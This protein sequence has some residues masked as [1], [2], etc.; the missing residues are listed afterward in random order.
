M[1]LRRYLL[2]WMASLVG[3]APIAP[4]HAQSLDAAAAIYE[5][6]IYFDGL[7]NADLGSLYDHE[8]G[9]TFHA[10]I[11]RPVFI[12]LISAA[13]LAAGGGR[14]S[15]DLISAF[16][17]DRTIL[18]APCACYHVQFRT[19]FPN[20]DVLQ[21]VSLEPVGGVWKVMASLATPVPD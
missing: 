6:T 9:P 5:A 19:R 3:M 21:D 8:A 14:L 11:T 4:A 7:D 2:P 10:A 13:R 20:G 1:Q 15:R 17:L 16:P 18:G 12:A